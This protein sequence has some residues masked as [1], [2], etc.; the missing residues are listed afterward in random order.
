MATIFDFLD[1]FTLFCG[2]DVCTGD[3]KAATSPAE[4][5]TAPSSTNTVE[6]NNNDELL[7]ESLVVDPM[8]ETNY[9]ISHLSRPMGIL[10]EE[11]YEQKY[12]G[13]FVTEINE[14][15]S[16]AANGSICRGDQ[17]IAIGDKRVS[18]LDFDDVIKLIH[19]SS[20][21]EIKLT[22][23]RGPADCLYG[24]NGASIEWLNE[25][26]AERGEEAALVEDCE[27]EVIPESSSGDITAVASSQELDSNHE[28]FDMNVVGADTS[29]LVSQEVI[30]VVADGIAKPIQD[31][32]AH[33]V[34]KVAEAT[35][36]ESEEVVSC[37]EVESEVADAEILDGAVNRASK[38]WLDNYLQNPARQVA[39][40]G[41][42]NTP[43]KVDKTITDLDARVEK[44]VRAKDAALK[45]VDD[46][47][48]TNSA[49]GILKTPRYSGKKE[50]KVT[51]QSPVDV[52]E[53][54][55]DESASSSVWSESDNYVGKVLI[56]AEHQEEVPMKK[57]GSSLAAMGVASTLATSMML[58]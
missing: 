32:E 15:C 42:E 11:N 24:P 14:G 58:S 52:M 40:D 34:K 45:A 44:A 41:D 23:F 9:I 20:E 29:G 12:G 30:D 51:L 56:D 37:E 17:L 43:M 7:V 33:H 38:E 25:F 4:M 21:T 2:D 55:D 48:N 35:E 19:D 49:K 10:F 50:E 8:D 26:V 3:V 6:E 53:L 46:K 27:S 54:D 5:T 22:L 31:V 47:E 28:V 57:V 18:G 36:V 13:A 16:A 39:S 1:T